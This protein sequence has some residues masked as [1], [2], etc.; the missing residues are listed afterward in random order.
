M[1]IL[2]SV[3]WLACQWTLF[4]D[5]H[6]GGEQINGD[7]HDFM[8]SAIPITTRALNWHQSIPVVII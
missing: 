3:H 6:T 1:P 7:A 5:W 4:H 2:S 8:P